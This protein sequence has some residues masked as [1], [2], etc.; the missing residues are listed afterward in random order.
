[1]FHDIVAH[2][3]VGH[4]NAPNVHLGEQLPNT[5][6]WHGATL[7]LTIE[8]NWTTY[9]A[10]IIKWVAVGQTTN[11][12]CI[13]RHLQEHESM[14]IQYT[15]AYCC[16]GWLHEHRVAVVVASASASVAAVGYLS[17]PTK[18]GAICNFLNDC[19]VSKLQPRI[20]LGGGD[21][22]GKAAL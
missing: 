10:K 14:L 5:D 3:P 4:R 20:L 12:A 8:G 19:T 2:V 22:H 11:T 9:R 7:S 13:Q 18:Q 16:S 15:T 6:G 21:K 17:M 1:L